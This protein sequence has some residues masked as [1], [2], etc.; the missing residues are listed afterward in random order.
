[1]YIHKYKLLNLYNVTC[2]DVFRV[3]HLVLGNQL[4]CSSQGKTISP[5]LSISYL[6]DFKQTTMNT[7]HISVN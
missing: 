2:I 7:N 5:T 4:V 6:P 3:S 1:M